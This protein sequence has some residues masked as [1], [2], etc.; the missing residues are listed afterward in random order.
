VTP[1]RYTRRQAKRAWLHVW[2]QIHSQRRI[3][4]KIWIDH[5]AWRRKLAAGTIGLGEPKP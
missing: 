2:Q 5:V 1:V 3:T 4:A